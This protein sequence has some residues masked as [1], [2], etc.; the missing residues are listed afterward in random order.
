MRRAE[1]YCP[2]DK[3][4]RV[5]QP[6]ELSRKEKKEG[7]S[8][9]ENE[10]VQKVTPILFFFYCFLLWINFTP[11]NQKHLPSCHPLPSLCVSLPLSLQQTRAQSATRG[12]AVL[13][14]STSRELERR[15]GGGSGGRRERTWRGLGGWIAII[16][17]PALSSEIVVIKQHELSEVMTGRKGTGEDYTDCRVEEK[18]TRWDRKKWKTLLPL[19]G[20]CI[21]LMDRCMNWTSPVIY[22]SSLSYNI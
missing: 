10:G 13:R 1:T 7:G 8:G 11:P 12:T 22:F 4:I 14:Y 6:A 17:N 15:R 3:R 5:P 20:C 9:N 16:S 19:Q 2:I 18:K 21:Y